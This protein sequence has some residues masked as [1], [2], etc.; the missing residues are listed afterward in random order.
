MREIVD[1]MS[2]FGNPVSDPMN[3]N[4][5]YDALSRN[6]PAQNVS[7]PPQ[8]RV[9]ALCDMRLASLLVLRR[10]QNSALALS[11]SDVVAT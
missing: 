10:S 1:I 9:S 3:Q 5:S 2:S 6:R 8:P 7:L 11:L 4:I